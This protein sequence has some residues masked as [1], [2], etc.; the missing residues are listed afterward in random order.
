M[1]GAVPRRLRHAPRRGPEG[2]G[3]LPGGE[4]ERPSPGGVPAAELAL[5]GE[6]IYAAWA[7]QAGRFKRIVVAGLGLVVFLLLGVFLLIGL[8]ILAGDI[9][10]RQVTDDRANGLA[11]GRLVV[12]RNAPRWLQALIKYGYLPRLRSLA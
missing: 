12:Q 10:G 7:E 5:R 4:G 9:R 6:A 11:E 8:D 3:P 1:P 2:P